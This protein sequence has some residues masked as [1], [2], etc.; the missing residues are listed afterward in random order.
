VDFLG[1]IPHEDLPSQYA[2]ADLFVYPSLYETFGLPPLEAMAAG[3][4]V[5]AANSSSIPE[6]VGDAA[7][8]VDPLSV[9]AIANGMLK[10]LVDASRRSELTELGHARVAHFSWQ[11]TGQQMLDILRLA[12]V[13]NRS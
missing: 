8:L 3:C 4:P 6:I 12:V 1:P 11:R 5:V 10:V 7:E 2:A 13:S 9:T